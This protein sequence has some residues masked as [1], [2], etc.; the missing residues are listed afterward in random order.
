MQDLEFTI[1]NGTL[2]ILQT[3]SGKRTAK[4]S[5]KIAVEMVAEN[6]ISKKEALQRVDAEQLSFFL[7]KTIDSK[8]AVNSGKFL[9]QGL[10]ASAGAATGAIVFS[11]QE[12][13][14]YA[15]RGIDAI[16]VREITTADDIGMI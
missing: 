2:Y 4:A 12:A 16:L 1:E 8:A 3:R 7:H 13:E 5:T 11:C 9:G 10:A 14:E 15:R 6:L